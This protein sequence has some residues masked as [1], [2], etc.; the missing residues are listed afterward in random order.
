M[1]RRTAIWFLPDNIAL[2][3]GKTPLMLQTVQFCPV[4]SWTCAELTDMGI[5]R[6]FIVSDKSTHEKLR[7]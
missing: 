5:E 1:E 4:L 6:L 2:T 3:E 7:P